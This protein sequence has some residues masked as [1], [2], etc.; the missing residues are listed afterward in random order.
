MFLWGL[1]LG[2]SPAT[3][4]ARAVYFSFRTGDWRWHYLGQAGIGLP[5]LPALVQA[6]LVVRRRQAA[7]GGF[8]APPV[9]QPNRAT[10]P[11]T[12]ARAVH[13]E[14]PLLLVNRY[15]ESGSVYT[16]I[17]GLAEYPRHLRRLLWTGAE[18]VVQEEGRGK[19]LKAL[20]GIDLWYAFPPVIAASLVYAATRHEQMPAIL[21][22]ARRA[23]RCGSSRLWPSSWRS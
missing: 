7:L 4:P 3:G 22:H 9:L 11:A 13:A 5:A 14:R 23:W 6:F 19:M 8:M 17:A 10:C 16:L 2:S 15:F 20:W 12:L 1:Y 21:R 18:R